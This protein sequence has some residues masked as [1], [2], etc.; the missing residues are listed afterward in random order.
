MTISERSSL[1][2]VAFVVCTTLST[3]DITAVLTGGSA[4]TIYAPEAYQSRDV[5]FIIQFGGHDERKKGVVALAELGYNLKGQTYVH[6]R[7]QFTL[8]FPTGPLSI[9]DDL[10]K[11]WSIMRRGDLALNIISA[12]DCV[13][14][15][16]L[17]FYLKPT[18]R[19]S[20]RAAVGA[21]KHHNVDIDFIREW[22][23]REGFADKF[24]EFERQ[25]R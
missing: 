10:V 4:A 5:D 9:G 1:D 19:S 7:N 16:L 3:C 6:A 21:A 17:W 14:D 8:E 12:T 22:S 11:K 20:L 25:L 13:R 18:D 2:D 24:Y 23:A 15:R